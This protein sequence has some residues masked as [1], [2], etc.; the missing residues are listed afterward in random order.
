MLHYFLHLPKDKQLDFETNYTVSTAIMHT[1]RNALSPFEDYLNTSIKTL[2]KKEDIKAR[3]KKVV[4]KNRIELRINGAIYEIA[5]Q[6]IIEIT[7]REI[8]HYYMKG[9]AQKD[10][11]EPLIYIVDGKKEKYA[12]TQ[13]NF[14][15][16]DI[17]TLPFSHTKFDKVSWAGEDIG[18]EPAWAAVQIGETLTQ[19]GNAYRIKD[20]QENSIT[21]TGLLDHSELSYQGRILNFTLQHTTAVPDTLTVIRED[22]ERFIVYSGKP[23]DRSKHTPKLL[24][25]LH[26]DAIH[27]TDGSVFTGEP[28]ENMQFTIEDEQWISKKV[29]CD[30]VLFTIAPIQ[31]DDK[32]A[33]WIQL[34]ELEE[35]DDDIPGFSPLKY[36]FDDEV[37]VQSNGKEYKI[38]AAIESEYKIILKGKDSLY[39]FPEGDILQVKV[40]TYQLRKQLEA[41]RMLRQMP[42]GAHRNIIKLFEKREKVQWEASTFGVVDSAGGPNKKWYTLFDEKRSGVTAQRNF[43]QQALATP[44]FVILEGPP[45]SGKTTVILELI[46]QLI[47]AKKRILLCGSTHVAIDNVLERLHEQHGTTPS[48]LQQL[49]ILP[50]RIGDENRINEDVKEFQIDRLIESHGISQELLL[51]SANLVCGTTIGILQHPQFKNR[52]RKEEPIVPLFDYLI[53]DESSKTTFQEF[54]VPALYAKKWVLVGDVM[55][56]SPF[57]DREQ[58]VANIENIEIPI[59]NPSR[60]NKSEPFILY[61]KAAFYLLKLKEISKYAKNKYIIPVEKNLLPVFIK[62]IQAQ[63]NDAVNDKRIVVYGTDSEDEVS[64][65]TASPLLL[66][67]SDIIIIDQGLLKQALSQLPETHA[68]LRFDPW[69]ESEHA[70][71]HNSWQQ[72]GNDF[73]FRS[74]GREFSSSFEITEYINQELRERSWAE[75]IAWRIDRE[76]QLRLI[77][78]A[79]TQDYRKTIEALLPVSLNSEEIQNRINTVALIAFPSILESL[80]KGVPKRFKPKYSSE[81]MKTTLSEGFNER[82]RTA[83]RTVLQYQHRMHPEISIFPRE[84]F[85]KKE[86]ALKD[87]DEPEHIASLREWTYTRYG[88]RSIWIDVSGKTVRNY[89]YEEADR[90]ISELKAFIQYASNHEQPEGKPWTAACLTFYRG[91]ETKIRERL[92]KVTGKEQA[93]AHFNLERN[94]Q[95]IQIKLYSVDKFQGHEAD[96]VFLSMV[97]TKRIGFMDN[98]NRLNVAVTRAKFQLVIIGD[99]NYFSK[100]Q[101]S[102]DLR[103]LA[104]NTERMI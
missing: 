33:F 21:V 61:Q 6:S 10:F 104:H 89:N 91:Q 3:W 39:C 80:I 73:K 102:D 16:E 62:E 92:Q 14:L 79:K 55:Q 85:Y 29:V 48:L 37:Y 18:L 103:Q 32:N 26:T 59:N 99:Y 82:E 98:P 101:Q 36:F 94:G 41:I 47:A 52:N 22:A 2:E 63:D 60:H 20:I 31:K 97:Q 17:V 13:S 95:K 1:A 30:H 43:V 56:L 19:N 42:I 25:L 12:I 27:F 8:G 70:F 68:V 67:A 74:R 54:L 34:Q 15:S 40:N 72:K 83:R 9:I 11:D 4:Q 58:I 86:N 46:C 87:L 64:I 69:R 100:Q 78:D 49:T 45:G 65:T 24:S 96:I 71:I 38:A 75:E 84:Q 90:L 23:Q 57:T 66:A 51:E 76:H 35:T 5:K 28:H 93:Y 88:N 44:D 50:V 77:A 81:E 53:I 7:N